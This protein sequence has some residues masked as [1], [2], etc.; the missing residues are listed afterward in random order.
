MRLDILCWNPRRAS[1]C[2]LACGHK[3]IHDPRL[4]VVRDLPNALWP[5]YERWPLTVPWALG[6]PQN[7]NPHEIL[8]DHNS[9]N[10]AQAKPYIIFL[11]VFSCIPPFLFTQ[12]GFQ[13]L[14]S[15][16]NDSL[17]SERIRNACNMSNPPL[18]EESSSGLM[19]IC[20]SIICFY[21][22]WD[23][24]SSVSR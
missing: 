24:N 7:G 2:G 12:N 3:H 11:V 1:P 4:S 14:M 5:Y 13:C 8:Y 20:R 23:P 22:I 16:L 6:K 10:S 9:K 19:S 21:S 18:L 17:S 15:T